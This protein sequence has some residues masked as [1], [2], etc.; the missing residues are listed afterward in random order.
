[1]GQGA[2]TGFH[3]TAKAVSFGK[4]QSA[5][6]T[7]AYNARD[8]LYREADGQTTK[9]YGR[10]GAAL[11]TG[12][13]APTGAP[14][15]ARDRQELWNRAE[16][17]ERQ[18]ANGQPARNMFVAF[19]HELNQQQREWLIKDFVREQFARK[20]MIADVAI[21]APDERGD[22]RNYHAHILLTM[23]KLDG[24]E[25]AKTKCREWNGKEQL[26]E[27]REQWAEKGAR[28]LSRA[29]YEIEAER[30]RHGHKTLEQQHAAALARGDKEF[31]E[32]IEGRE[33]TI[34]KGA[35]ITAMER[36]GEPSERMERLQEILARNEIRVEIRNIDREVSQL[37]QAAA[38]EAE[39]PA[40]ALR[41]PAGRPDDVARESYKG[42]VRARFGGPEW[43]RLPSGGQGREIQPARQEAER[44]RETPRQNLRA[45]ARAPD[46]TRE[47]PKGREQ[48][49]AGLAR[50][51]ERAGG[52]VL[53]GLGKALDGMASL[54][55]G[56][57]GGAPRDK[58][59][60]VLKPP[61][62]PQ[63]EPSRE[64][65][66]EARFLAD[67]DRAIA[68]TQREA[69]RE[70]L[71]RK[72]DREV[73]PETERDAEIERANRERDRSRGGRER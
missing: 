46:Y 21:H 6:H 25:F 70:E 51:A 31:A 62:E 71:L 28:A 30:W 40:F 15:W 20:G 9:D 5:V 69:R 53:R 17:A 37:R 41:A 8:Q 26:N 56:L 14:D 22:E 19:P 27:W 58:D 68:E 29:G 42:T 3:L 7:A 67:L 45:P 2:A 47:A 36:R 72:F 1:M 32:R 11:F 33:A 4:G 52:G 16:A 23:R 34:H 18:K 44:A 65:G 60:E 10:Y 61:P 13:F 57:L 48:S 43:S 24:D 39:A 55:E 64:E 38:R 73:A 50:G 59:G 54:F 35:K 66:G 49:S 12:I 63:R